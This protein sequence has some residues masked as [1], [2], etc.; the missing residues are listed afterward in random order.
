MR[1]NLLLFIMIQYRI[2]KFLNYKGITKY[3]FYKDTGLS[4]GFLDKKGSIGVD[5]CEII[6]SIYP[7]INF[8]WLITG[9]GFMLKSEYK[10]LFEDKSDNDF[11]TIE[12]IKSKDEFDS[13]DLLIQSYLQNIE[14][15]KR[16][17]DKLEEEN[18]ILK[19]EL[20]AKVKTS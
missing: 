15:Q 12:F 5:K 2:I 16:L 3:K 8:E 11:K 20:K 14:I 17:I 10:G 4:N 18:R 1:E 19:E 9:K 6:Y 13:K 7:E